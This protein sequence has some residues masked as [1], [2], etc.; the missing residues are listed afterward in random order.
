M[1]KIRIGPV[2]YDITKH[3][4]LSI[5]DR[6]FAGLYN[7]TTAEIKLLG[8]MPG[9]VTGAVLL[10]E[11]LHGILT[12]AGLTD[13]PEGM[14]DAIAYGLL[15]LARNNPK[16]LKFDISTVLESAP[17][18][19]MKAIAAGPMAICSV[20]KRSGRSGCFSTPVKT[21]GTPRSTALT[22]VNPSTN[23]RLR[24][25]PSWTS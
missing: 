7:S 3:E 6:D 13:H 25:T 19:L 14:I 12:H 2:E 18:S 20:M 11:I 8:D 15:D 1:S 4:T 9:T 23:P 17:G 24:Q 5:D 10:H 16:L 21:A 22:F